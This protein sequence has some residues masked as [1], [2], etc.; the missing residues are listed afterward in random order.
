MDG[1]LDPLRIRRLPKDE[2]VGLALNL[3]GKG[4][5]LDGLR[6]RYAELES[7]NARLRSLLNMKIPSKLTEIYADVISRD[8]SAWWHRLWINKGG[9]D[10]LKVGDG[11]GHIGGVVGK[12]S[13]VF[14]DRALVELITSPGFRMAVQLAG[15]PRPFVFCGMKYVGFRQVGKLSGLPQDLF[16][17][18]E[19]RVVSCEMSSKFPGNLAVG[20]ITKKI[21][22]NGIYFEAE[23]ELSTQ[24]N[25]LREVMV[26]VEAH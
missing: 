1:L 4:R 25:D 18:E 23:C 16:D 5:E 15:D 24:L 10:G 3:Q 9:D 17:R 26:F 21:R 11:V 8:V 20:S 12:V 22:G 14:R 7:E 2:L 6:T 19:M 13:E